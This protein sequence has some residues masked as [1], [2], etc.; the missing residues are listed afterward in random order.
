MPLFARKGLAPLRPLQSVRAALN[1]NEPNN[2]VDA[3]IFTRKAAV[4]LRPL[5]NIQPFS[6][7]EFDYS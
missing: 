4:A 7:G 3:P 1:R 5:N 6:N 2:Q